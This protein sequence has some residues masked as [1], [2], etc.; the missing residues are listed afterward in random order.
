MYKRCQI[1]LTDW[2]EE[3]LKDATQVN[4]LSFSEMARIVLSEGI[5]CAVSGRYPEYKP[6][7]TKKE[8][9]Q[10]MKKGANPATT[11]EEKHRL[12]AKIYFEARKAA[13]YRMKKVR[14]QVKK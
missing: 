14:K 5:L 6:G 10:M 8:H 11:P 4:D 2:Q 1:L 13:E 7:I 3:Y 9:A 12:I